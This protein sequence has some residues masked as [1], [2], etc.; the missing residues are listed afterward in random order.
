MKATIL[1]TVTGK[2][3]TADG[4]RSWE[5]ADNNWSCDCNRNLWG[6]DT[7]KPK[8]LCEGAERFLV[9]DAVMDDPEDYPYTL[10]ELNAAYPESLR[11]QLLKDAH[12]L[13]T[14]I[15]P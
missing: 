15:A 10:D 12:Y 6:I 2:T 11:K 13:L 4:P 1:D 9:V 7:G 8:G 5:W 3:L 14:P